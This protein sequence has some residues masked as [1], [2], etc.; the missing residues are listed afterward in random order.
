MYVC[1]I[2]GNNRIMSHPEPSAGV[3]ICSLARLSVHDP[4]EDHCN[5]FE[6]GKLRLSIAAAVQMLRLPLESQV[7]QAELACY[8]TPR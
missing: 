8:V 5:N 7:A 6:E 2:C 1:M 3:L 4:W